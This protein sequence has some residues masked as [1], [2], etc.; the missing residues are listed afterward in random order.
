MLQGTDDEF[1]MD[2]Y[3]EANL[4]TLKKAVAAKW[5]GIGYI[6]GMEGSGKTTL[7]AQ[8]CKYLYPGMTMK[9]VVFTPEQF[10][11]VCSEAKPEEAILFDESYLTFTTSSRFDP[12]TRAIIS[13]LTMIRKKRLYILIVAPTF[14]DINKYIILHRS[15]FM[16]HVYAEGL[17][18]GRFRFFNQQKKHQLYL[19]GKQYQ[20]MYVAKPNF[21]GSFTGYFPFN[22]EEYEK[23]KD[24]A[25]QLFNKTGLR[26]EP[27]LNRQTRL[28][29]ARLM[30]HCLD[31]KLVKTQQ[32][33]ADISGCAP[34]TIRGWLKELKETG[35]KTE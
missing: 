4:Q 14:F 10:I 32:Q 6:C 1:Y 21:I 7:G 9:N 15:R 17:T 35:G 16:I 30:K 12:L 29:A 2:G 19:K 26:E 8:M 34:R 22:E 11:K 3:L 27:Q 25:I 28:V 31:N 24:V 23:K 5:D 13:M 33:L 20:N 18:R